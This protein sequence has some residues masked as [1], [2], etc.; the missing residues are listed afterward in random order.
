VLTSWSYWIIKN[1]DAEKFFEKDDILGIILGCIGHDLNHPGMNNAYFLKTDDNLFKLVSKYI[2]EDSLT[3]E[4][5][6]NEKVLENFKNHNYS[7]QVLKGL[8]LD[9]RNSVLENMH[10]KVILHFMDV[11][12]EDKVEYVQQIIAEGILWTDMAKHGTLVKK[13]KALREKYN[14]DNGYVPSKKERIFMAAMIVHACDL[15]NLI[16]DYDHSFKWCIRITQEF[17]DQYQAEEKLNQEKYGAPPTFLKYSDAKSFCKGQIG[18]MDNVILPMWQALYDILKFDK[19][20]CGKCLSKYYI[21]TML[22]YFHM[23]FRKFL[24]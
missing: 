21:F 22:W 2:D 6:E 24:S 11:L 18:F 9:N 3:S 12:P 15:S 19:V 10:L 7:S 14:A 5:G 1:I 4:S 20:K 8:G 17:H 23:K 13:L 16:F